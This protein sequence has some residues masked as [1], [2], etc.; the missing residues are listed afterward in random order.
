MTTLKKEIMHLK[1][2]KSE[3]VFKI[4]RLEDEYNNEKTFTQEEEKNKESEVTD[5]EVVF[6]C[7]N[8]KYFSS[9]EKELNTNMKAIQRKRKCLNVV[10]ASSHGK[11]KFKQTYKYKGP[12]IFC[13]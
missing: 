5:K 13:H 11:K 1:M 9:C 3:M 10:T 7:E 12:K 8:C 4:K 6:N 2:D